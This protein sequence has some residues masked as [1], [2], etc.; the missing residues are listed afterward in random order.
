VDKRLEDVRTGVVSLVSD[1][2]QACMQRAEKGLGCLSIP[3]FFPFVHEIVKSSS[4]ARGRRLRQAHPELTHAEEVLE[5][6]A[7]L[8][9][10]APPSLEAKAHVEAKHAEVTPWEE[11]PRT[12]RH[13]L[14]TLSLTRHP[15]RMADSV[16]QNSAQVERQRHVEVE[17]LEAFV[18]RSPLPARPDTMRKVRKQRPALAALVDCWWQGVGRDWEPFVLS[19]RWRQWVDECLLPMVYW[20]HQGARTRCRRRTARGQRALAEVQATTL[21]THAMTQRLAPQVL[22]ALWRSCI[23][24]NAGCPSSDTRS[25]RPCITSIVTPQMARRPPL[26]FS[27]GRFQIFLKRF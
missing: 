9:Y 10:P 16:P 4:L 19:P 6:R 20:D 22:T 3:D 24:I 15:L 23:I 13:P 7:A 2:A 5:R 26:G 8:A 1:R 27:G 14:A 11:I 12:S 17:A 18:G 21:T 25:G